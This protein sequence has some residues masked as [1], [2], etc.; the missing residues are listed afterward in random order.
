MLAVLAAIDPMR[1]GLA[2]FFYPKP[3]GKYCGHHAGQGH[4][5]LCRNNSALSLDPKAAVEDTGKE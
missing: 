5:G 4:D 3:D 2:N 1:G